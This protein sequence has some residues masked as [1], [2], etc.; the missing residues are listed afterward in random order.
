VCGGG[1][2][3]IGAAALHP[4]SNAAGGGCPLIAAPPADQDF[5]RCRLLQA[6]NDAQERRLA[7]TRWTEQH[8]KL[9]VAHCQADAIDRNNI[10][11]LLADIGGGNCSHER[12]SLILEPAPK[13][14]PMNES[15][16]R[17]KA[18]ASRPPTRVR[19]RKPLLVD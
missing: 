10:A 12:L 15:G 19:S 8:Q 3:R 4:H 1:G 2:V 14:M 6:G 5:A 18:W 16:C 17:T 11:E 9:A 7:A 13:H